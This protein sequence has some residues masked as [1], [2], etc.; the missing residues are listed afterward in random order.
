MVVFT[1]NASHG[2]PVHNP[3]G[4]VVLYPTREAAETALAEM[5]EAFAESIYRNPEVVEAIVR[6]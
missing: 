6:D 3:F 1:I 4:Q 2:A 5:A